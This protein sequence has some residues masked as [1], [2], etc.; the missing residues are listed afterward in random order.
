MSTYMISAQ[1]GH[2]QPRIMIRYAYILVDILD[3]LQNL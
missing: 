3:K 1:L 2:S